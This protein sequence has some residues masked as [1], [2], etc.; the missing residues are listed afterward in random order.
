MRFVIHLLYVQQPSVNADSYSLSLDPI[1]NEDDDLLLIPT[2]AVTNDSSVILEVPL[3]FR[4]LW[5]CTVLAHDCEMH[6]VTA[7]LELSILPWFDF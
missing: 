7:V 2:T 4:K 1:G 3:Q 5:N 6:P